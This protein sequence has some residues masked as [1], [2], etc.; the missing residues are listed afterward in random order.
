MLGWIRQTRDTLNM[1]TTSTTPYTTM[2][3][4][5]YDL[6]RSYRSREWTCENLHGET[7]EYCSFALGIGYTYRN[8]WLKRISWYSYILYIT[9]RELMSTNYNNMDELSD[10]VYLDSFSIDELVEDLLSSGTH[11]Y[12]T[13]LIIESLCL[14][15]ECDELFPSF[16]V[17]R[18]SVDTV[19]CRNPLFSY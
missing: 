6:R 3:L 1:Q 10:P 5:A 2:H 4:L 9:L 7:L 14:I 8:E 17:W 19:F 11:S 18:I 12:T 13:E 15:D 16:S